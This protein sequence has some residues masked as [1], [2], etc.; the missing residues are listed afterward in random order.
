MRWVKTLV[1][2]IRDLNRSIAEYDQRIEDVFRTHPDNFIFA[3]FRGAGKKL[4]PRL[5]AV[6]GTQRD[7]YE[8]AVNVACY[9]GIAPVVERSGK[10]EWVRWRWHCPKFLRQSLVEFAAHSVGFSAWARIYY[11]EQ[12]KRGKSH[13]AAVRVLGFSRGR[14]AGT[15]AGCR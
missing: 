5:I 7:R 12:I 8:K 2:Q 3:S 14:S 6:F 10:Q 4:A 15:G 13:Q 1:V 9:S 11:H